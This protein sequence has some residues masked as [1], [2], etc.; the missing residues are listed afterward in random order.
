MISSLSSSS[1]VLIQRIPAM[2]YCGMM[3][4]FALEI[5]VPRSDTHDHVFSR[6]QIIFAG[7]CL[8]AW[9]AFHRED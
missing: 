3:A 4:G 1:L 6:K 2:I 9:M 7:M 8:S 5:I